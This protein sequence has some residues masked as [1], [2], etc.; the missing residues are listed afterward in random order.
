MVSKIDSYRFLNIPT[1]GPEEYI[2]PIGKEL[3]KDLWT[4]PAND[5]VKIASPDFPV[6]PEAVVNTMSSDV[7]YLYKICQAVVKGK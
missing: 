4:L 1:T 5:F 7:K 6:V 2:G 3:K